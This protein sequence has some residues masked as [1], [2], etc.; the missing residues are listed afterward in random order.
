MAQ[1]FVC[2]TF[3][4]DNVSPALARGTTTPTYI[5]RGDFGVVGADPRDAPSVL[6]RCA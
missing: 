2:L 5:S 4:Y 6:S 1:H 3:D